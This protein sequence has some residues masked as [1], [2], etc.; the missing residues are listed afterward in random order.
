MIDE[1][2]LDRMRRAFAEHFGPADAL[3]LSRAPGRVN[4]IGEHTDYNGGYVLPMAIAFDIAV[5]GRASGGDRVR[6]HSVD[7]GESASF[8]PDELEF[9]RERQ[10]V[11]YP[12][13]VM[14]LLRE[15]GMDVPT[16]DAVVAGT[17]PIGGGL[18]SSAAFEVAVAKFLLE[19]SGKT[20]DGVDLARLARRAENEFVGVQCGIMDQFVSVFAEKGKALFIDCK[21]LEHRAIPLFGNDYEFVITNSMV[22]HSLGE[23]AYH[24]RQAE[25]GEG[26]STLTTVLGGRET[27]RD[28]A[29]RDYRGT[30]HV[31][32]PVVRKRLDHVFSENRRVLEAV[33]AMKAHDA[34][35]F[36][37]LM[38]ASHDSLRDDYEVSCRELDVLVD[39]AREIDGVLGSRMTGGGFG[40]CTV[41]LVEKQAAGTFIRTVS[42]KYGKETGLEA[43]FIRTD[44]AQGATTVRF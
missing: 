37:E 30:R 25:C 34:A 23:T 20:L 33:E 29:E 19:L 39:A 2:R 42:S 32:R 3:A 12:K 38:D 7:F 26:L 31:M 6:L 9:D 15:T 21:T 17:V 22:R 36:G 13:G 35:A 43:E 28:V 8:S 18:S 4:L 5:L 10:W 14:K 40:G 44:A 27:L 41:S 16:F 11:N 1:E 24:T